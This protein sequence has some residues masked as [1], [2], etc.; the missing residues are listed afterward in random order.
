MFSKLDLVN[1]VLAHL[2]E[3]PYETLSADPVPPKLAK[4]LRQLDGA[5]AWVLR[6]HPW[7]SCLV[8]AT[9]DVDPTLAGNWKY[10]AVYKLPGTVV[11]VFHVEPKSGACGVRFER[12]AV[13]DGAGAVQQVIFC[14]DAGGLYVSYVALKPVEA[15][16]T[17]VFNAVAAETAARAAGPIGAAAAKSAELRKL[18]LGMIPL[19]QGAEAGEHGGDELQIPS[20]FASLRRSA[21]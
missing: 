3:E 20:T 4:V 12:G 11:R 9:L 15:W 14:A 13:I 7:L 19:A 17:D 6:R 18:A 16:D 8:H 2:G 21:L 5:A 10:A 1:L